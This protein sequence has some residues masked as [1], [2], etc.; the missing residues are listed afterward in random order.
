MTPAFCSGR[1]QR[2]SDEPPPSNCRLQM[3]AESCECFLSS[4]SL[5]LL[6]FVVHTTRCMRTL[7]YALLWVTH[8]KLRRCDSTVRN[9]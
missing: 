9:T 2:A 7:E 8:R 4:F 5:L 1:S 3:T 6:L